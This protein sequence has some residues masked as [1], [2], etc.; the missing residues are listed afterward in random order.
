MLRYQVEQNEWRAKHN[1]SEVEYFML[2]LFWGAGAAAVGLWI[3]LII[4]K[5]FG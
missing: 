4:G 1:P 2:A 5:I 3:A